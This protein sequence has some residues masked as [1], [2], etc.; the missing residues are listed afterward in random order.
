[1][2]R[3]IQNDNNDFNKQIILAE[4]LTLVLSVGE[5]LPIICFG[6]TFDDDPFLKFTVMMIYFFR[7]YEFGFCCQNIM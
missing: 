5:S 4:F 2:F 3:D 1:M 7:I 6:K